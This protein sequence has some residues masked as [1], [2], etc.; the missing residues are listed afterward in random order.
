MSD[1]RSLRKVAI[2][3]LFILS[4][5]QVMGLVWYI[6]FQNSLLIS[7]IVNSTP[8]TLLFFLGPAL[9]F[10]LGIG[11]YSYGPINSFTVLLI[12]VIVFLVI[13]VFFFRFNNAYERKRFLM[14]L[15]I[16]FTLLFTISSIQVLFQKTK[17]GLAK[18]D[19]AQSVAGQ[20]ELFDQGIKIEYLGVSEFDDRRSFHDNGEEYFI[21]RFAVSFG[22]LSEKDLEEGS[23]T[24]C[25][26]TLSQ[27][28]ETD[29]GSDC[30]IRTKFN[31][32]SSESLKFSGELESDYSFWYSLV[33]PSI[34]IDHDTLVLAVTGSKSPIQREVAELIIYG[35]D[36]I[37]SD[38][39]YVHGGE[40]VYRK[41]IIGPITKAG[42]PTD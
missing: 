6:F 3:I 30:L 12:P 24:L 8:L 22:A 23:Y 17:S 7:I 25:L 35:S 16:I 10:F 33:E 39:G 31:M 38:T 14:P 28:K 37:V 29:S 2:N 1:L 5:L 34:E 26:R 15:A 11:G 9:S 41:T 19:R 27:M 36:R 18:L 20:K 4:F 21:H 40:V 13:C 42:M 32:N